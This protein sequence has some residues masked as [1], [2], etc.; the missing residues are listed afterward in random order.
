[1]TTV[2]SPINIPVPPSATPTPI[3]SEASGAIN[4]ASPPATATIQIHFH[5]PVAQRL[6][7]TRRCF[8]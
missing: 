1:V 6:V 3:S 8:R 4:I 7:T 2:T 5:Q